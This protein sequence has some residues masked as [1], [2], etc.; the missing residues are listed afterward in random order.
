[1][2]VLEP[3]RKVPVVEEVDLCVVGGS[4]TGVFAAIRAA[5][6]GLR[7]AL[8]E[9]FGCLGGTATARMV[10]IWHSSWDLSGETQVIGGLSLELMNRLEKRGAVQR[11]DRSNP[12]WEFC[13]NGAEMAIELD[14]MIRDLNIRVFLHAR[15]VA[16]SSISPGCLGSAI[17][18]DKSGRRAIVARAFVDASGDADLIRRSGFD[19]ET[20]SVLQPP[21]MAA[22]FHGIE[23]GTPLGETMMGSGGPEEFKRGF[24]WASQVP[25]CKGLKAI[26][27]TRV[28]GVDCSDADDLS[29]AEMEGRRQIRLMVDRLREV[30]GEQIGLAALPTAIGVRDS[31]RILGHHRLGEMELLEGID[32]NDAIAHGTYRIDIHQQG[33]DGII[34]KYLDGRQIHH[35]TQGEHIETRWREEGLPDT[36][37]Y[38]VPYRSLLPRGLKNVIAA[39]RC[40]CADDGAYGAVRVM[41]I[42]NQM[43]E[44]AGEAS[45]LML[46]NGV[47]QMEDVSPY[48]LRERLNDGGSLLQPMRSA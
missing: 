25:G 37:Y 42:C 19:T 7:V 12:H 10:N 16:S 40:L 13:F 30:H 33:G 28:H 21:T 35:R 9:S 3:A 46:Q 27:G 44:A 43:G 18:E 48:A 20:P 14:E 38:S 45:A 2:E 15:V 1:M 22:I 31:K 6:R 26:F 47:S 34:F 23:P 5:R 36:P 4:C 8:V 24:L 17:I 32:F 41:I 39:G 11:E 29:N